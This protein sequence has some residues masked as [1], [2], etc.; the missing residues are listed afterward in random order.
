MNI[1][2]NALQP[3]INYD[4]QG[5][6][7]E[8]KN[9]IERLVIMSDGEE[10]TYQQVIKIFPESFSRDYSNLIVNDKS[11]KNAVS[12]KEQLDNFEKQ[13][14]QNEYIK[15]KKNVS[16]MAA[17]LKTDRPNLHRKLKKFGIKS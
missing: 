11:K 3:M 15:A 1:A 6:I 16:R 4:W 2:D 8:L 7:R 5:N 14:L 9:F 12:L 17:N 13:L 10:I